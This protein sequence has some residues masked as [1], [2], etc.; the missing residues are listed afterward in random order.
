[1]AV[2]SGR[3]IRLHHAPSMPVVVYTDASA[4]G[5]DLRIGVLIFVPDLPA[6]ASSIDVPH[7]VMERW[8]A[9]AQYIGQAE[10]LAA[11]L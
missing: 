4:E 10:L 2:A 7:T 11:P 1:M 9:R 8:S 5:W 6:I 3:V